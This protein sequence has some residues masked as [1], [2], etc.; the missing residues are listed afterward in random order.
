MRL[1]V[2]AYPLLLSSCVDPNT[3]DGNADT[4]DPTGGTAGDG[5]MTSAGSTM[6]TGPTGMDTTATATD[7]TPSTTS[8]ST[9]DPTTGGDPVCGDAVVEGDEVCDDGINDG[10]Y[11]GCAEDCLSFGPLCGDNNVDADDGETCDDGNEM[12][13]DGCN[14]DCLESGRELWIET[15]DGGGEDNYARTVQVS[16]DGIAIVN[17]NVGNAAPPHTTRLQWHDIADGSVLDST[18]Y[19]LGSVGA[20][21]TVD[22]HYAILRVQSL[23]FYD[24]NHVEQGNYSPVD[25]YDV[26][27]DLSSDLSDG[28]V[29]LASADLTTGMVKRIESDANVDWVEDVNDGACQKVVAVQGG[30]GVLALCDGEMIRYSTAGVEQFS[31]GAFSVDDYDIRADGTYAELEA[32]SRLTARNADG[33]EDWTMNVGQNKDLDGSMFV[34]VDEDGSVVVTGRRAG[35][36]FVHKVLPDGTPS[37]ATVSDDALGN[38]P[39]DVDIGP[40]G[41]IV[42][43]GEQAQAGGNDDVWVG[44]FAP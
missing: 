30:G 24:E 21:H 1:A 26:T 5:T 7:T 40:D 10:S 14:N 29:Y 3:F 25:G 9:T 18:E 11:G 27:A 41:T 31:R 39:W 44:A 13:G 19:S 15:Y 12:Q 34:A 37:W 28:T 20:Q 35:E 36:L 22:D 2:L 17:A 42:V 32:G 38:T 8:P 16:D 4:D 43:V 33:S 23:Y 6:S